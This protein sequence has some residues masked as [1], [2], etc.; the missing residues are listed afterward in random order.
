MRYTLQ[1]VLQNRYLTIFLAIILALVILLIS[2]R[3]STKKL[4][5]H[6]EPTSFNSLSRCTQFETEKQCESQADMC[7]FSKKR[8]TDQCDRK[9]CKNID[10]QLS[11][12][13]SGTSP[14]PIKNPPCAWEDNR[15]RNCPKEYILPNVETQDTTCFYNRCSG[16]SEE[17]C[18][19]DPFSDTCCWNEQKKVCECRSKSEDHNT[20]QCIS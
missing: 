15:C 1:K 6:L 2:I 17:F 10:S 9:A 14:N 16:L 3:L 20:K 4:K 18:K 11:C 19:S 5:E 12:L 8:C 13:F 7:N